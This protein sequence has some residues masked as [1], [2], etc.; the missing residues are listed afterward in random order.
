[1]KIAIYRDMSTFTVEESSTLKKDGAS[2]PKGHEISTK[3][4]HVTPQKM[5]IFYW[6]YPLFIRKE[7]CYHR[8]L[9]LIYYQN[10]TAVTKYYIL[11]KLSRV[12]KNA[13]QKHPQDVV[14]FVLLNC[15]ILKHVWPK[16]WKNGQAVECN[17]SWLQSSA[18]SFVEVSEILT[19]HWHIAHTKHKL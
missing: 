5:I 9:H 11:C 6:K 3:V 13:H 10:K 17:T 16:Y 8:T 7:N 18:Q 15:F 2:S 19:C 12:S 4:L 14:E 1:M